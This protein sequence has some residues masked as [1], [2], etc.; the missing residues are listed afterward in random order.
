MN[1]I[2]LAIF[3]VMSICI[4]YSIAQ[5]EENYGQKLY[6]QLESRY[7]SNNVTMINDAQSLVMYSVNESN[8]TIYRVAV[9]TVGVGS[10]DSEVITEWKEGE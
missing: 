1:K 7:G 6:D 2:I 5:I 9:M 4:G 10:F 8:A 3:L